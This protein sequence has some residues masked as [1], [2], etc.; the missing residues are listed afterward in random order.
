MGPRSVSRFKRLRPGMTLGLN[1]K[2]EA[3]DSPLRLGHGGSRNGRGGS[4]RGAVGDT[5]R[6][7]PRAGA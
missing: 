5:A 4:S 1:A 3:L 6:N 2:W 7:A